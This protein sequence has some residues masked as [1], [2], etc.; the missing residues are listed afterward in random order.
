[1]E[2]LDLFKSFVPRTTRSGRKFS[3]LLDAVSTGIEAVPLFFR[4]FKR[5]DARADEGDSDI[6]DDVDDF[7]TPDL[8]FPLETPTAPSPVATSNTP[9]PTSS[10]PTLR[11]RSS[12]RRTSSAPPGQIE[13]ARNKERG[14]RR[15]SESNA[16]QRLLYPNELRYHPR[17]VATERRVLTEQKTDFDTSKLPVASTAW[18]GKRVQSMKSSQWEVDEL[19][20]MG[21]ESIGWDGKNPTVILDAANRVLIPMAG[22]PQSSD[23]EQVV[24]DATAALNA[25]RL[26]GEKLGIFKPEDKD[27]RRGH[28]MPLFSGVSYGGGQTKPGNLR[29]TKG[30]QDLVDDLRQNPAIQRVATFQS[31]SMAINAPKLYKEYES[32]VSALFNHDPTLIRNFEKSIFTASTFNLGPNTITLDHTDAANVAHGLCAI[33][34]LGDYDPKLGGHLILFD[35]GLII[36]FPPGATILIPSAVFRHGNTPI[37]PGETRMSFTQYVAGGLFRWVKYGFRTAKKLGEDEGDHRKK[38]IDGN[39]AD[40]CKQALS[41]FSKLLELNQ[42]RRDVFSKQYT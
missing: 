11:S 25:A 12:K 17:I 18:I 20:E 14:R 8:P 40:R 3:R 9:V 30:K 34:A 15:R 36:E 16:K 39:Y 6:D 10:T 7:I 1:M 37:Q 2:S 28:Y 31:T 41:L 24:S 29:L 4:A 19:K 13:K 22:Q 32:F 42:D 38:E 26:R 5:D 21:F 35:L 27:H 33:T 23:W